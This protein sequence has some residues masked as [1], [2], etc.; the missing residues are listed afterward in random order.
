MEPEELVWVPHPNLVYAIGRIKK[1]IDSNQIV[2][3]LEHDGSEVSTA[4]NAIQ[5]INP[6]DL[7][8]FTDMVKINDLS[9]AY[10]LHNLKHR[11]QNNKIYT[12]IG[13][14]L[15]SINPF[16][17]I[18]NLYGPEKLTLYSDVSKV[19]ELDPHIFSVSSLAYAGLRSDRKS[20]SIIISGESGSGKT[21]ASKSLLEFLAH[22]SGGGT[23]ATD[24]LRSNPI[25][26]AFGN[27]TTTRN[28]NSSRF[29]KFIKVEFDSNGAMRGALIETYLLE[30]SRIS[31]RPDLGNMNYH[32]FYYLVNGASPDERKKWSLDDKSVERFRYLQA[33]PEVLMKF[34]RSSPDGLDA[35]HKS[36]QRVKEAL[37]VFGVGVDECNS[38]FQT[39]A[40]ILH[41]GNIEFI[42]DES[43]YAAID[44]RCQTSL[45]TTAQLLGYPPTLFKTALISRNLKA[46]GRGSV[47]SR[48]MEVVQAEEARDSLAKSLYAKIFQ[49][50]VEKINKRFLENQEKSKNGSLRGSADKL[51]IGVL[52]IFGFE[53]M[54]SNSLEQLLINFT[55]EKLQSQFIQEVFER[56]QRDYSAEG[57]SWSSAHFTDNK[58]CLELIEKKGQGDVVYQMDGWLE[59]NRDTLFGDLEELLSGSSNLFVRSLFQKQTTTTT[60]TTTNSSSNNK[61]ASGT[62]VAGQFLEQL[63][64][65]LN[66][67]STTTLSYVRCV[68]PNSTLS[69]DS[70]NSIQVITQLR[71][72]GL[73]STVQVRKQGYSYR[74]DFKL[75]ITRYSIILK[76]LQK[77]QQDKS[78]NKSNTPTDNMQLAK[79]IL[80]YLEMEHINQLK[81]Q[82]RYSNS[83]SKKLLSQIGKTKVFLTDELYILLEKLR[84]Q[85]IEDA[86]RVIQRCYKMYIQRKQFTLKRQSALLLQCCIRS[87]LRRKEFGVKLVAERKR[88]E[89]ERVR[90]EEKRRKEEEKKR[91][92]EEKHRAEEESKRKKE[93]EKR[94]REEEEKLRKEEERL[95]KEEER[96]RKEE[97]KK[98]KEEEKHRKE[99]EKKKKKERPIAASSPLPNN[100]NSAGSAA[101]SSSEGEEDII[102]HHRSSFEE[103]S[104]SHSNHPPSSPIEIWRKREIKSSNK[105]MNSPPLR[106][107]HHGASPSSTSSTS[108]TSTST[109]TSTTSIT[110]QPHLNTTTTT[111]SQPIPIVN[112]NN[113]KG[114]D[115]WVARPSPTGRPSP[116]TYRQ[117][118][119]GRLTLRSSNI[120]LMKLSGGSSPSSSPSSGTPKNGSPNSTPPLSLSPNISNNS[121]PPSVIS[122]ISSPAMSSTSSSP[123]MSFS[124]SPP[125][126]S[127]ETPPVIYPEES[128]KNLQMRTKIIEEIIETEKDYVRDL[129]IVLDVFLTPIRDKSMLQLKD[130]NTLFSNLEILLSIN[131]TMLEELEKDDE[132]S[133]YRT[134][135][136]QAFE[137]MSHY[138]KMYN[139]YCSNQQAALKILEDEQEKNEAFK[140][141]LES[142]MSDSRCRGLPLLSFI[143]KPVQRICKYPLLLRETLRYTAE[144]HPERV[145][146][147]EAEKKINI[148]VT[149]V[150]EGKRTVEMFQKILEI[151]ST[152]ENIDDD[153]V[154]PGRVLLQ[155]A[156]VTSVRELGATNDTT[157]QRSIFLF[158]DLILI[159][160]PASVITNAINNFKT[161]KHIYRLKGRIPI[162]EARIMFVSDTDSVKYALEICHL[163]DDNSKYILCFNT[164]VQRSQWLK[165]IK[166]MIQEYKFNLSKLSSPLRSSPISQST[167]N[168]H[169]LSPI[170]VNKS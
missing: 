114:R 24:I 167:T 92:E 97:E 3:E 51:F 91:K 143:I 166:S 39:V 21:E 96:L 160:G 126:N 13:N 118:R 14:V 52:D 62:S 19:R 112:N 106:Q 81:Q 127:I 1:T 128:E 162:S 113:G 136:G 134:K 100:S 69:A 164:E 9:E 107:R 117:T 70:F 115:G 84:E 27:A 75:F 94:K 4:K 152:I 104:V 153:L 43:N 101:S 41:L 131:K 38:I 99:E 50:I 63:N 77:Q 98:R 79:S 109:S 108:T 86:V 74:R 146:L 110:S 64:S 6:F 45:N 68:K 28:N 7:R 163:K 157:L 36:Y 22:R 137:K 58:Q 85:C 49:F 18:N 129:Q 11:Y 154:K 47:Y 121:T 83:N 20:Q 141:F 34:N 78:T 93:E 23:I 5:I 120:D 56:E 139:A 66:T 16:K 8:D 29:G 32:I 132:P 149:S 67:L 44:E 12:W 111:P 17:S 76:K 142:C 46:I 48:P 125:T 55:N 161:K 123:M 35:A 82:K 95:R 122:P 102:L 25:L 124:L 169:S 168:L 148:V 135:V 37:M 159:C 72:V 155:E 31:H 59:K 65:L 158:N 138:L 165:Q 88:L 61:K 90:E 71:S 40:A 15:V 54:T 53:N 73:L 2:V 119:I 87:H 42:K 156:T 133:H 30:K 33:S 26:E 150:N 170:I 80:E 147:E 116:S 105:V 89:E 140:N 57:I 103:G 144:H 10:L 60:A 151:Q 145:P 130:I